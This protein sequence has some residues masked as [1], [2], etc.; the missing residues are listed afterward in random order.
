MPKWDDEGI[1][2]SLSK[3]GEKG[4]L[5]NV[6]TEN[7][8][9]HLGWYSKNSK[10]N[11]N[12]QPG[13]LIYLTW[14]ARLIHQLGKYNFEL[15]NSSIGKIFDDKIRLSILSS[16]CSLINKMLP[17]REICSTFY[18]KSKNF[19]NFL[20]DNNI[21]IISIIELYIKW[22]IEILKEVG[23]SF[24]LQVCAISGMRDNLFYLS[25]KTGNVVSEN[26]NGKYLSKLLRLPHFLG[27]KK[28]MKYN[29][30][31]DILA[32][33]HLTDHFIKS[34]FSSVGYKNVNLSL[35]SRYRLLEDFK[36][37]FINE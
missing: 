26:Y 33:L 8:G 25:P 2:I 31:Q 13:D 35:M 16:Y 4:L 22:E 23:F 11:L 12:I 27:G 28:G 19:L 10:K 5:M 6:Y 20:L 3:K 7:H 14:N 9:R 32:G 34:F 36:K 29:L 30:F 18:Y 37:R 24:N 21:E 15:I 17:E 1:V